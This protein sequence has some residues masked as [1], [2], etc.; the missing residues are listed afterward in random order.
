MAFAGQRA[1]QDPAEVAPTSRNDDSHGLT[2]RWVA[3]IMVNMFTENNPTTKN[4][5]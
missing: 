4:A 1:L 5:R 3:L 2:S